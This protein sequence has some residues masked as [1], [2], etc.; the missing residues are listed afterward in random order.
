M[1]L[2]QTNELC[3][4][5]KLTFITLFLANSLHVQ[6][7]LNRVTANPFTTDSTWPPST[8]LTMLNDYSA[9]N[10]P[11]S[12]HHYFVFINTHLLTSIPFFSK[13]SFETD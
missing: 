1:Q 6:S 2:L 4:L 13:L 7:T 10:P 8:L 5:C 12:S 9:D 3:A 11:I